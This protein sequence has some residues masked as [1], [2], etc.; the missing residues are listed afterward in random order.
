L[1]GVGG[2]IAVGR[3][4]RLLFRGCH[5][6]GFLFRHVCSFQR[7]SQPPSTGRMAPVT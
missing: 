3:R 4:F 6:F 5:G 1:I 2:A 7:D